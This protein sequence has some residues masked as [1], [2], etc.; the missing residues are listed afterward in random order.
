[1][2]K[3][4]LSD[5]FL[6]ALLAIAVLIGR[7]AMLKQTIWAYLVLVAGLWLAWVVFGLIFQKYRRSYR[8][9]WLWQ[10]LL[11]L[12]LT[13]VAVQVSCELI[14]NHF[15]FSISHINAFWFTGIVA[16]MDLVVTI[17][18]HYYKYA[19][20]MTE[21]TV[22][23]EPR[24][25]AQV[26][27]PDAPRSAASLEAIHQS[28]IGITTEEHYQMLLQ[29]AH[30]DN[31][32]TKVICDR[33]MFSLTQLTDYQ[34]ATIV[35][36]T[37]LTKMKGVNRRLCLVNQK[38][39]D[40]GR[41]IC[42]YRPQE[43]IKAK[44]LSTYPPVINYIVYAFWFLY[45]RVMPR[46]MLTSRLYY[47]MSRGRR[48]MMSKT[49]ALGRLYY[50][51]FEVE[52]IIP[53][54]HIEYIIA[55]RRSQPQPQDAN[56]VYG[57]LI[58]LSRVCENYEIKQFYKFR[59][60][61]PYAEY[62]QQYVFDS[63]GGMNIADKS[64]DDWRITSWGRILRKYWLDEL[65]MLINWLKGDVKLVGVRPLSRAMFSE[66][67]KDLQFKRTRCKPGLIPPFYLDHPQ[68]F[69]ELYASEHAYLDEYLAHPVRTDFKYFFLTLKSILF[70]HMHS[71]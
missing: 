16:V 65:P 2:F 35:D 25:E 22:E 31:R 33:E 8:E 13:T 63:R 67:P 49:E 45:R 66:Y 40:N 55:R 10:A 6:W 57:P 64:D 59:T 52:E 42:C 56:K 7:F 71:A 68:T 37:L 61:H 14:L 9:S 54:D 30:L 47:D 60:M 1:M 32:Q 12:A 38:L 51:G 19:L 4:I 48:R 62:I 44:I 5:T 26:T 20:R 34:Y 21:P 27:T 3:R 11:S 69:E 53:M 58:S 28:V 18:L 17:S 29:K 70:K 43:Y 24:P 46:L 23:I 36:M 39:P 41:Y 50:C 15:S